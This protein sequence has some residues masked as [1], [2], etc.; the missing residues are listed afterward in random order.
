[1]DFDG[2]VIKEEGNPAGPR[3]TTVSDLIFI[4]LQSIVEE[5]PV[6]LQKYLPEVINHLL[7]NGKPSK[8][9]KS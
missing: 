1:M 7:E 9:R 2:T 8:D 4:L 6:T 5:N 3:R